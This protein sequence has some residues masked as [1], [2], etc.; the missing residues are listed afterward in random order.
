[1]VENITYSFKEIGDTIYNKMVEI[2][3]NTW[4]VGVVYNH[5]IKI[6]DGISLP[7]VIITPTNG[8]V[9][10]LDSCS[11]SSQINFT[12]RLMDRINDWIAEVEDNLRIVADMILK[13]LEEIGSI[14]WTNSDWLTVKCVFNYQ[15]GF[16]DTQEPLRVF[17]VNCQFTA[18]EK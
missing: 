9:D 16:V 5:D 2:K 15:W 12:V 3:N 7:A 10:I 13:G 14:N 8:N 17:S 6:E 1:M 11:L 4:R 18:I